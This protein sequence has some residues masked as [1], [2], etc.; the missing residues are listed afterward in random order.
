MICEACRLTQQINVALSPER[1]TELQ[2]NAAAN[3]N[4]LLCSAFDQMPAFNLEKA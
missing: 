1:F 3:V 4:R 2:D